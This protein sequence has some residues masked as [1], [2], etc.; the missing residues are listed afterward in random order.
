MLHS[1]SRHGAS[2]CQP[3]TRIYPLL[4]LHFFIDMTAA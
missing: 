3:Q 2:A 1:I 4:H